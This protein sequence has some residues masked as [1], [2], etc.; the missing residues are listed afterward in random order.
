[1]RTDEGLNCFKHSHKKFYLLIKPAN[2]LF[3]YFITF[4][5]YHS[6]L[7]TESNYL[8][9]RIKQ[10]YRQH[11]R[12]QRLMNPAEYF[13][14][15]QS[16]INLAIVETMEQQEKEKKLLDEKFSYKI[17]ST[18]EEI[19]G[20]KTKIEIKDIFEKCKDPAKNILVL[21]R[22]GIG[23]TTF[24]R[25][26][27][28]QWAKGSIWQQYQLVVLIQLRLLTNSRYPSGHN[29]SP[30]DLVKKEYF[31]F[32][33]LSEDDRRRFKEQCDKGQIL[34]LL[35]GYDEFSQNIPEQLKDVFNHVC[36]TQHHI[37]TA[38]PYAI[39]LPYDVKREII[40]FTDDN[41]KQYVEQFFRQMKDKIDN[42]SFQT[43]NLLTFLT[44]N[45]RIWG[46]VHIPV[47]LELICSL[48][49]GT[50]W[51]ETSILTMTAVYD[52]M[53]E[54]LCRR[55][56]EKQ[57]SAVLQMRKSAVYKRCHQE[58][59]FL[60]SL[61]FLGMQENTIILR[62][63]LL[64]K[65]ESETGYSLDDNP[66]LLNIG[67]LK[68]FDDRLIGT[69]IEADKNYY[70][71]HLSF[72]EHFAAR[73]LVKALNGTADQKK[74]AIDFIKAN[75]YNQR[76]ELVFNF[77]SGRLTDCSSEQST[78]LF[79]ETLLGQPLDLIGLRHVQIVI[80]CLEEAGCSESTPKY[81]ES[82][83]LIIT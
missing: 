23:K 18:Y 26:V 79:W 20:S 14:I 37:M 74:K 45:P 24:C 76:F 16:Y 44:C 47:N 59:T 27:A 53:T 58:L 42:A 56:L 75:K 49:C 66:Y 38:R 34:W 3:F 17:I 81:R 35:D 57:N 63:I 11:S 1:L 43:E 70:F 67:I 69:C 30:I 51:S 61:A 50:N 25:Y 71:V 52:K 29:Y 54:W 4:R 72:Q 22:A 31:P 10:E 40:G 77:A 33:T 48:W 64:E 68:S 15:E 6:E 55:H 9:E 83:D 39:A 2:I 28:Y 60:E 46:I 80:S 62:P 8:F 32:D 21:G 36:K 78:N 7:Q 73:Y 19:Y 41:I 82:M 5:S 13:P 65:A 12:I